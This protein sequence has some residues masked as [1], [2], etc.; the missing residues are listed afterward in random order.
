MRRAPGGCCR[1]SAPAAWI[2]RRNRVPIVRYIYPNV[3]EDNRSGRGSLSARL[4]HASLLGCE[5]V[6]MPADFIKNK[7]E[8]EL[9]GL[10][11][12]AFL[13][14]GAAGRLYSACDEEITP[15]KYILRTEPSL[16]GM[17]SSGAAHQARLCWADKKWVNRFAEMVLVIA[18][19]IGSAPSVVEIHPG[20]STNTFADIIFGARVIRERLE[21]NLG[22]GPRV[23]LE[24]RTGQIVQTGED[25]AAFWQAVRAER[26][27]FLW[28]GVAVDADLLWAATRASFSSQLDA[29]P[30]EAVRALHVHRLHRTPGAA[31]D[32]PWPLVFARRFVHYKGFVINPE[33]HHRSQVEATIRFCEQQLSEHRPAEEPAR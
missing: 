22:V 18:R 7:A 4:A 10:D 32:I 12:G 31:D 13:D 5:L 30:D 17:E 29:I 21:K 24:N 26:G 27:V 6:E 20:D 14:E 28:L 16:L 25:L 23:W 8:V 9:T 11:L 2:R 19:R 33:V 15:G 3:S 1:I